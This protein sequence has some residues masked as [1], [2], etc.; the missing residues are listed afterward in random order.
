[1]KKIYRYGII[2]FLFSLIFINN[3]YSLELPQI[4]SNNI[5][6]MNL[7]D[8]YI[9]YSKNPEE[10]VQIASL[11]KIM[12]TIVSIENINDFNE[13]IIVTEEM[14][15]DID[16]DFS[17]AGFK[18]GEVITYNDLLYGTMLPSGADATNI[19]AYSISG[20][21]EEFVKLM[22]KKAEELDMNDSHFSNTMG[23]TDDNNYSTAY[24][25]SKLLKYC[26]RNEKFKEVYSSETYISSNLKHEMKGPVKKLHSEELNMDYIIGAKT[27]YTQSAGLCLASVSKYNDKT[28]LLVTLGSS[29]QSW[30]Q[31]MLDSKTLY[32]YFFNNYDYKKILSKGDILAKLKT[33]YD[34]EYIVKSNEDV[35]FYIDKNLEKKDLIY[36]YE[37]EKILKKGIKKNDKIGIFYIMDNDNILYKKQL[38]S[39]QT[40]R[41][42]FNYFINHN[43]VFLISILIII[44]L[45]ISC[46]NKKRKVVKNK[47]R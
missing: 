39:P 44:L 11:T 35:I 8:N 43:K 13:Q 16:I 34:E 41:M 12:T 28:Y 31:H 26:I 21:V 22:N 25:L 29:K 1:M 36:K 23:K 7:D 30:I 24:D 4:S 42:T 46:L 19:L 6:F 10:K 32:E 40:V 5:V 38:Y 18:V 47:H 27:G 20:S 33:E 37:G 17:I 3:V 9:I 14:L 2:F 15:K 45:L